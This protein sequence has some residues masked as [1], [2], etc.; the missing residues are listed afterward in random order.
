L[1]FDN[2][3]EGGARCLRDM[4]KNQRFTVHV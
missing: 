4:E 3:V 2:A 1:R